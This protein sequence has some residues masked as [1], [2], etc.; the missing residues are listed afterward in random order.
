MGG[1]EYCTLTDAAKFLSVSRQAVYDAIK[2]GRIK[3]Y[4]DE[5]GRIQ[6][7]VESL[8]HYEKTRYVRM[9]T[10]KLNG[11]HLDK[12]G[13]I[14]AKAAMNEFNLRS[15]QIYYAIR[16]GYLRHHMSSDGQIILKT[17]DVREFAQK[18]N[19]IRSLVAI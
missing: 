18:K 16:K 15:G 5:N 12:Y 7:L 9:E 13:L 11:E 19:P 8:D 2:K 3:S 14:T 6:V 1:R 4:K 10:V 17:D